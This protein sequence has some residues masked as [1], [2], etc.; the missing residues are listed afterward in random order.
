MERETADTAIIIRTEES[1]SSEPI[2]SETEYLVYFGWY[3]QLVDRDRGIL[4]PEI[5]ERLNQ[6]W[7]QMVRTEAQR[8]Q[9]RKA[10]QAG[11]SGEET[12]YE[13][14]TMYLPSKIVL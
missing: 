9:K 12:G 13:S 3:N 14:V 2:K 8:R 5:Q 4:R 6:A 11:N 7:Q 1:R 10:L